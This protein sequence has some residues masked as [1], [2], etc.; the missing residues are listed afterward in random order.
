MDTKKKDPLPFVKALSFALKQYRLYS[1]KHPITQETLK[2]LQTEIETYFTADTR[3]NV[4]ALRHRLLVDGSV[5]SDKEAAA[6]DFA[7]DLER[8]SVEG[9]IFDFGLT[10]EEL[11]TLLTLM[12]LR[13]KNLGDKGGFRRAFEETNFQHLRLSQGKF[14][15]VEEGEAVTTIETN[16]EENTRAEAPQPASL[17]GAGEIPCAVSTEGEKVNAAMDI[18]EIIKRIRLDASSGG[19]VSKDHIVVDA[20]KI[21]SQIEK[22]PRDIVEEA[23]KNADDEVKLEGVIRQMVKLLVDGIMSYLVET[24]KDI[25]KALDKLAREL[26]K[27]LKKMDSSGEYKNLTGKIPAIFE[28]AADEMRLQM[29]RKIYEKNPDDS[30]AVEKMAK[31]LFKEEEIRRR[32]MPSIKEEMRECGMRTET[33]EHLF[34]NID[35]QEAKKKSKVTVDADELED[36]RR[37]AGLFDAHSDG[38]VEKKVQMLEMENKIVRHQ[39]ERMDAVIRNLAEGLLVVDEEGKVVLMNPAAEKLLGVKPSEKMGKYVSEGLG[40]AHVVS[41]AQGNLKEESGEQQVQLLGMN[42]E[43]KRVLKASTAV[44]ENENG[45]TVGMVSV[46][47]DITRQK[48]LEEMKSKFVANV[49]HELRTPLV[50]IQKSLSVILEQQVGEINEQQANFLSIARRNIE[51]LSRLINDL[52]DVS[53]LEA[54]QMNLRPAPFPVA[55]IVNHVIS[56]VETWVRDKNITIKTEYPLEEL[57]IEADAD[58]IT[59]VVTNLIGNAIKFTPENG[60][61]TVAVSTGSGDKTIPGGDYVQIGV[62]DTGIGISPEDQERI[63]QKFVQVS[64]MKP[65]GVAST[66]LGLTITKELVELHSGRIWVESEPEKGSFFLFRIPL[67]FKDNKQMRKAA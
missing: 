35:K 2:K 57:E 44:I 15:L 65:A 52:L 13:A 37:K 55:G 28:E 56:T 34:E 10:L 43:T 63:F 14:Q 32:L 29:I 31:K 18:T 21:V 49:S 11:S 42:D 26:E 45:Q 46:L 23:L 1:E 7:K 36:L 66:G 48:E 20:E 60:T 27:S 51:R 58:R 19:I 39:K 25:T 24:G 50:A 59:Q 3:M 62:R 41:M 38:K 54:G 67:R 4:G 6:H 33:I 64:L 5:V 16:Q 47:S 22:N 17:S 30:K 53:R 8:L 61:I 12:S 40:N 9:I